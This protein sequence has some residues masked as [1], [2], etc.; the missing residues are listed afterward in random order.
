MRLRR[1]PSANNTPPPT[2]VNKPSPVIVGNWWMASVRLV[3]Y[4]MMNTT[5]AKETKIP[6][7]PMNAAAKYERIYSSG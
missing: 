2:A 3:K 5:A 4:S 7:M 1:Y 6:P